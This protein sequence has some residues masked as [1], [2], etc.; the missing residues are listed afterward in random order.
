MDK[1]I[2]KAFLYEYLSVGFSYPTFETFKLLKDRYDD[3]EE[4]IKC[5]SIDFNVDNFIQSFD[6]KSLFSIEGEY[7]NLF[8]I[9]L[10]APNFETAYELDKTGRKSIELADLSGFYEAFGLKLSKAIEPDNIQVELEFLSILLQKIILLEEKNDTEGVQ[11]CYEA[12]EKFLKEHIGRWYDLF[13]KLIQSNSEEKYYLQLSELLKRFM[14]I[15]TEGLKIN[16]A[17]EYKEEILR[18]S[19]WECGINPSTN[20]S[21]INSKNN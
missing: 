18:E 3:L 14:D 2:C 1:V 15:E 8:L 7:N 9:G 5:L 10:K 19:T 6:E 17:I 11:I 21:W 12:Y 16:K 13:V 4:A 20:A